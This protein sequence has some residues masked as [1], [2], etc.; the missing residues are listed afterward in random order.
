MAPAIFR[1]SVF[2]SGDVPDEYVG[3]ARVASSNRDQ[4]ERTFRRSHRALFSIR[5]LYVRRPALSHSEKRRCHACRSMS[6]V[7]DDDEPAPARGGV[8]SR[9]RRS[10]RARAPVEANV[11]TN[12]CSRRLRLVTN[13][14][15]SN[16][17]VVACSPRLRHRDEHHG[18][19][20]V[21]ASI[22]SRDEHHDVERVRARA[23][24]NG[25]RYDQRRVRRRRCAGS[26]RGEV[27]RPRP[28]AVSSTS[29]VA[30]V[31]R[32]RRGR[33]LAAAKIW[34]A[35][36]HLRKPRNER[37]RYKLAVRPCADRP[38]RLPRGKLQRRRPSNQI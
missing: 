17:S 6:D 4:K 2:P 21:L 13:G 3:R 1:P 5:V 38:D 16:A 15:A 27:C 14:T 34:C 11:A 36:S 22:T 29:S 28:F 33:G 26:D 37:C 32:R 35:R 23:D 8:P 9:R 7:I 20:R 18:V 31:A 30:R 19:E 25:S 10:R 12:A 24:R